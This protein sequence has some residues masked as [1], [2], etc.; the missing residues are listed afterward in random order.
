M[1]NRGKPAHLS[2]C[3][4]EGLFNTTFPLARLATTGFDIRKCYWAA[5]MN[6]WS[7]YPGSA[8][9]PRC[10]PIEAWLWFGP[11]TAIGNNVQVGIRWW[12]GQTTGTGPF[13]PV[14]GQAGAQLSIC[15]LPLEGVS[16]SFNRMPP[17]DYHFPGPEVSFVLNVLA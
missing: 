1:L 9:P 15:D 13:Y 14:I 6:G 10:V 5:F 16:N 8:T 2:P 12:S 4:T 11:N 7:A 3:A 17:G